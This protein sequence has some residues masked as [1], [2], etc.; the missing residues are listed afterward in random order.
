MIENKKKGMKEKEGTKCVQFKLE[1][2]H[3]TNDFNE[4]IELGK[5]RAHTL[6]PVYLLVTSNFLI[7]FFAKNSLQYFRLD[8]LTHSISFYY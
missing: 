3:K 1:I 6:Y 5:F 8:E 7:M 2:H 4:E